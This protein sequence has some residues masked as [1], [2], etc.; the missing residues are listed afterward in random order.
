VINI[1]WD[2]GFKRIYKK[3]IKNNDELKKSFS[4]TFNR[5]IVKEGAKVKALS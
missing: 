4:F 2:H 1:T 3:M 5:G